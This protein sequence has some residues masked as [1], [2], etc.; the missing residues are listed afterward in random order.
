MIDN[1]GGTPFRLLGAD[2]AA[3]RSRSV[4]AP[5]NVLEESQRVV[6]FSLAG[7][8]HGLDVRRVREIIMGPPLS[9]VV[10]SP[11]FVDGVIELRGRIVPVIDLKKRLQI[12]ESASYNEA[13]VVV[14]VQTG[15]TLTGFRVDSVSEIMTVPKTAAVPPT[16]ILG[17]VKAKFIEGMAYVGDRLLVIL[18]AD[19]L[20]SPDEESRL[21]GRRTAYGVEEGDERAR[22]VT[23]ST[24]KRIITFQLDKETYGAE[25]GEVAEIMEMVPIMPIPHVPPFVL[26][27]VNLRGA[28][29][30]IV[31]LRVRFGLNG[32]P[33]TDE[34]RI[35]I[36]KAGSFLVGIAV[37][38]MWESLKLNEDEFQP[39]PHGVAKIDAEYFKEICEVGGRMVSVLDIKKILGDTA[40]SRHVSEGVVVG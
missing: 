1:D 16:E 22:A 7:H 9:G 25:I 31:D 20:L 3:L 26:G 23:G 36:M 39:P 13:S 34:A 30:P 28:I 14:I 38:C 33:W 8:E 19:A 24:F 4:T 37:D 40:L 11:G 10:E 15:K 18:N 5:T 12:G 2:V 17:G 32:S 35:V 21:D 27:L 6:V 29:V